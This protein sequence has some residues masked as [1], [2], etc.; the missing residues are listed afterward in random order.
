MFIF[1]FIGKNLALLTALGAISAYFYPPAFL[2]FK[3]SFLWFFAA[4]MFALGLVLESDDLKA[5]LK[6]PLPII[7]GLA[8]QYTVMPLLAFAAAMLSNLPPEIALGLI[9]VGCAP[10]A[11]A[12][13]V[14]VYL[15]GGAIA[16]SITLTT[17]A[18]LVSPLF[19][20]TLV[21]LLGGALLPI[22]FWPMMKTII[23]TVL[24]P[25]LLGIS[26]KKYFAR[27]VKPIIQIAPTIAVIAIVIICSYAIA[28]NQSRLSTV[29]LELL[30]WVVLINALG[31][32]LGWYLAKLYGFGLRKRIALSIEIGMQNAGLGVALALKH[33]QAETALPGA[34]FAVWCVLTAA[35][36]SAYLRSRQEQTLL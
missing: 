3:S 30:F 7:Y 4:T 21:E 26:V 14:V 35:G 16:Y 33:F 23:Y 25:V 9:I 12:S 11:M 15:A 2:I 6:Q 29:G 1:N 24:L 19:T 13:N 28:A 10:G 22:P 20:P 34:I 27:Q 32:V 17:I 36:M 5:T 18:T 31:Y 8:T